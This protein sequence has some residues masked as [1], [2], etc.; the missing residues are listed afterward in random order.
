MPLAGNARCLL[1]SS[2]HWLPLPVKNVVAWW[3]RVWPVA[4]LAL[5]VL[6]DAAWISVL[7]YEVV[8]LL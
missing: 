7:A 6:V 3:D 1:C 5:A 8:R 2:S 4:A